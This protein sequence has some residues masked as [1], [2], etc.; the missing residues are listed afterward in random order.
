VLICDVSVSVPASC[1]ASVD[2]SE[3]TSA[4]ASVDSCVASSATNV[5]LLVIWLSKGAERE[6]SDT[7][8]STLYYSG[9]S[10]LVISVRMR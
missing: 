1:E 2:A 9:N 4:E 6:S 3:E 5:S 7:S 10:S 8:T